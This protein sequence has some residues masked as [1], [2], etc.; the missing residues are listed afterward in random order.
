MN[1]QAAIESAEDTGD[2]EKDKADADAKPEDEADG[3]TPK[4]KA[5]EFFAGGD[6]KND[7]KSK[8][9]KDEDDKKGL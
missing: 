8:S 7:G 6:N 1:K 4:Q 5:A 3:K 2:K 9:Q